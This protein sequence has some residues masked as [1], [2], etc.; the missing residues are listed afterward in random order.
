DEC[1]LAIFC[2]CLW[3]RKDFWDREFQLLMETVRPRKGGPPPKEAPPKGPPPK[4]KG[5]AEEA[6][7]PRGR[8]GPA[9]EREQERGQA[10]EARSP[11]VGQ[12]PAGEGWPGA[13]SGLA[14]A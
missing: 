1:T 2:E 11:L 3:D 6:R 4:K 10:Q 7:G 12:W 13:R 9:R 5:P 14:P 8:S